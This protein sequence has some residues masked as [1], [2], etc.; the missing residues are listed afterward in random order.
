MCFLPGHMYM[1]YL[2]SGSKDEL[3]I[4]TEYQ[5]THHRSY[6]VCYSNCSARGIHFFTPLAGND[7]E[8]CTHSHNLLFRCK[9][10][11]CVCVCVCVFN[12]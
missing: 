5:V 7:I 4:V 11:V 8:L 9:S 12:C 6:N 10:C 2:K 3:S 1:C